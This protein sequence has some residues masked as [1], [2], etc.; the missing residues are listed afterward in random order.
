MTDRKAETGT[1][2]ADALAR[3]ASARC[4][5]HGMLPGLCVVRGCPHYDGKGPTEVLDVD[6]LPVPAPLEALPRREGG[7]PPYLDVL[8]PSQTEIAERINRELAARPG[9]SVGSCSIRNCRSPALSPELRE[10]LRTALADSL[11]LQ[12]RA[13]QYA[14]SELTRQPAKAVG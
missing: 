7:L 9:P 12:R 4:A 8:T 14:L 13:E 2:A 1:P 10:S 6:E 5:G 11:E 3:R